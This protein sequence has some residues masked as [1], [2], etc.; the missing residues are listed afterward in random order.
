MI[1]DTL[2]VLWRERIYLWRGSRNVMVILRYVAFVAIFGAIVPWQAGPAW[3]GSP[4]PLLYWGWL[5]TYLAAAATSGSFA[6]EREQ[7]TLESLLATR[8]PDSAILLGKISMGV[9]YAGVLVA[10]SLL[11]GQLVVGVESGVGLAIYRPSVGVGGFI[12]SLL[13]AFAIAALSSL[14]SVTAQ[15]SRQA[16]ASLSLILLV[17]F[18]P[19]MAGQFVPGL[20]GAVQSG[21]LSIDTDAV[22]LLVVLALVLVDVALWAKARRAFRRSRLVRLA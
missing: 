17:L 3:L 18:L 2:T 7:H 21:A 16:Q 20:Q 4:L 14:T 11:L 15:T 12:A 1:T 22:T 8:L 19:L 5:A 13:A 9:V 6:R 10:A